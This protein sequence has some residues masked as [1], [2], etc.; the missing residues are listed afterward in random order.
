MGDL[1]QIPAEEYEL[2]KEEISLLN[3]TVLLEKLNR[4]AEKKYGLFLG[5]NTANLT[6]VSIQKVGL[7]KN[8]YGMIYN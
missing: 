4:L 8:L 7:R 5:N 6:E 2:M 1:I 3:D